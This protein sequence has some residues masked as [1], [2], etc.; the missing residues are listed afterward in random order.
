[1]GH[2][3]LSNYL[4]AH[5][6]LSIQIESISYRFEGQRGK[7]CQAIIAWDVSQDEN[8]S[9]AIESAREWLE[10]RHGRSITME[11][12]EMFAGDVERVNTAFADTVREVHSAP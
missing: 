7:S 4:M 11:S 10:Q 3:L 2:C 5:D 1:M 12:Q 6:L 9:V 8:E